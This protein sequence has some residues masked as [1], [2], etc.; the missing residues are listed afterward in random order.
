MA[1]PLAK[2]RQLAK[3][4][5]YLLGRRPDEFGLLPDPDG[6][7]DTKSLLKALHEEEG[8]R[9]VRHAH[10]NEIVVSLSPS[11]IE[12]REKRIRASDRSRM[13]R[14]QPAQQMP[15]LLYIAI[16][17]RAYA[18]ALQNGVRASNRAYLLLS[19][20]RAMA[21]RLGKRIDNQPVILTVQV[22]NSLS[23]GVRYRQYGESLYLADT[24]APDTFSG[25][26]PPK[27][28]QETTKKKTESRPVKVKTP[29]SYFPESD[30]FQRPA[31]KIGTTKRRK[32]ADWHKA[33][34]QAR[35]HKKQ[36]QR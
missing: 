16:R 29:G 1:N 14:I 13:P 20:D 17:R 7:V 10:L 5:A 27:Q 8:W 22:A 15:K 3:F 36:G 4:L 2:T 23:K 33:R 12:I 25:P 30:P 34:R 26:P 32:E 28:P 35:K 24:V 31:P 9:H 21:R 6:F 19:A 11:P 18:A